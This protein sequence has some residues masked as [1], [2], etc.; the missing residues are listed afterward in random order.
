MVK[1]IEGEFTNLHWH[2]VLDRLE[3]CFQI[4]LILT[5]TFAKP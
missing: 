2:R 3:G 1:H 4:V 5:P